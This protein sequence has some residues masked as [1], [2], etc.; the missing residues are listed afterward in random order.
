MIVL[1]VFALLLIAGAL[2]VLGYDALTALESG[3]LNPL[4][5]SDLTQLFGER[6]GLGTMLDLET[7]L[8]S[9]TDWPTWVHTPLLWIVT[10]PAFLVVGV[11]GI[12]LAWLFRSREA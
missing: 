6:A 11:L 9:V 12:L 10:A 4:T 2:M 8:R 7:G 3:A 1:R 5:F